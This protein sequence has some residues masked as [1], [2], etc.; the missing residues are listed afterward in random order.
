MRRLST[1]LLI[2]VILGAG[3]PGRSAPPVRREVAVRFGWPASY[4]PL[5]LDTE[6][7]PF[8]ASPLMQE[9]RGYLRANAVPYAFSACGKLVFSFDPDLVYPGNTFPCSVWL[10]PY[11]SM[12]L[13]EIRS[14]FGVEFGVDIRDRWT[15]INLTS[16]S[17]DFMIAIEGNGGLPLGDQ[18]IGGYD[19][20]EYTSIPI[21]QFLPESEILDLAQGVLE[22]FDANG[23]ST[24]IGEVD[25]FG[26]LVV[27][28][29]TLSMRVGET[30]VSLTNAGAASA[31]TAMIHVPRELEDSMASTFEMPVDPCY[32]FTIYKGMGLK[33]TAFGPLSFPIGYDRVFPA[34]GYTLPSL[35][36]LESEFQRAVNGATV[37]SEETFWI[38]FPINGRPPLP[39]LAIHDIVIN[40]QDPASQGKA[41]AGE[42]TTIAF[43][44]SNVG[45]TST[46]SNDELVVRF[47]V[48]GTQQQLAVLN[49]RGTAPFL[50]LGTNESIRLSF[51][52][53]F[54]EGSHNVELRSG[55]IMLKGYD[56]GEPVYGMGDPLFANH[57]KRIQVYAGPPRGTILGRVFSNPDS[58]GEGINGMLVRLNGLYRTL[59]TT[60]AY[61]GVVSSHGIYRFNGVPAGDYFLEYLPPAPT[62]TVGPRYWPRSVR[63]HH[64]GNG[65]TDLTQGSGLYM[66]QYQQLQGLVYTKDF[67][68]DGNPLSNVTVRLCNAALQET[69]SSPAG[70]FIFTNVPPSGRF[71]LTFD[72]PD[73]LLKQVLVNMNVEFTEQTNTTISGYYELPDLSWVNSG[74]ILLL[75]DTTPPEVSLEPFDN[76]GR[77]TT[78]MPFAFYGSDQDG[79]FTPAAYRWHVRNL[80][81]TLLLE[82]NWTPW[83]TNIAPGRRV[84]TTADM[85]SLGEGSYRFE[86]SARDRAGNSATTPYQTLALDKSAPQVTVTVA[87]GA[88]TIASRNAPV[89][90]TIT[91]SEPGTLKLEL[92]NDGIAWSTPWF[93]SSN[94]F[95][96]SDWELSGRDTATGTVTVRAR[97]TDA[98]GLQTIASD[99]ITLATVG[100]VQLAYGWEA[101]TN[102]TVPLEIAITPPEGTRTKHLSTY[103][104]SLSV[105]GSPQSVHLAQAFYLSNAIT[106]NRLIMFNL[107][108]I[109]EPGP[110]SVRAVTS[111]S[112]S[113]PS[114]AATAA[115]S[116]SATAEQIRTAR[117]MYDMAIP[118][119]SG[120]GTV[121]PPGTNYL[122]FTCD[123]TNQESRYTLGSGDRAFNGDGCPRFVFTSSTWTAAQD[124]ATFACE[125]W[126][127]PNGEIR[128]CT[129]GTPDTE[130]WTAYS[131]PDD[132]YRTVPAP[133]EGLFTTVV[134]YRNTVDSSR[135][136]DHLDTVVIDM[137]APAVNAVTLQTIDTKARGVLMA[138]DVSDARTRVAAMKWRFDSN[139][140][141]SDA[142]RSRPFLFCPPSFKNMT[143]VFI[144]AAYNETAPVTRTFGVDMSAP[145]LSAVTRNGLYYTSEPLVQW[146]FDASDDTRLDRI[147]LREARTDSNYPAMDPRTTDIDLPFPK[148][149]IGESDGHPIHDWVD[150]TYYFEAVAYDR[151]SNRSATVSVPVTLDRR[152]PV[153]TDAALTGMA[154]ES[155]VTGTNLLLKVSASDAIGPMQMRWRW[156][157]GVWSEW[158]SLSG[159]KAGLAIQGF[160][161]QPLQYE[162]DVEVRDAAGCSIA[163]RC[164]LEV[165][166]PPSTPYGIRPS[167]G[168]GSPPLLFGSDFSDPDSDS[169]HAS[170]FALRNEET[171][172]LETG[173]LDGLDRYTVPRSWVGM[174][175]KY[176]WR[177]RYL[178]SHGA[179]S[180]WSVWLTFGCL[181]DGDGDGIPDEVE[182]AC[183]TDFEDPDTDDDGIPDGM[184]DLNADGIVDPGETNPR[185]TDTDG[186]GLTDRTE[187]ADGNAR[188]G[189]AETSPSLPDTDNDRADDR[190]EVLSGTN[191]R[192]ASSSFRVTAFETLLPDGRRQLRWQGRGGSAYSV[193]TQYALTDASQP[194]TVTNMTANGGTAPWYVVPMT[195]TE[196]AYTPSN[197]FYYIRLQ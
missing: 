112:N 28:G 131:F 138:L 118:A 115:W 127:S 7:Q 133:G 100:A 190:H 69:R 3:L 142:F 4:S 128:I 80:A 78:P 97:V 159:G 125:F 56:H 25:L 2:G 121:L 9:F 169:W 13:T 42:S 139:A 1:W 64:A 54:N 109:G 180:E 90:V 43:T 86:V 166:R 132:P 172:L 63:F 146:L 76:N 23:F 130:P 158:M 65:V 184:E 22:V 129:D 75:E 179:W 77:R 59:V 95:T 155:P 126:N 49:N 72:H 61:D 150:G 89:S 182:T 160:L 66:R 73:H 196:P 51:T 154:G 50:V 37:T 152:P 135:D 137:T 119:Q 178:D 12:D 156:Q 120:N 143:W 148:C 168:T 177:C 171:I 62:N 167:G 96:V 32:N 58:R 110:F 144:D 83:P 165:N 27:R 174:T 183:G 24:G 45:G 103:A 107:N 189:P 5:D 14:D 149:K 193:M 163:T 79:R 123:S 31:Q 36:T 41:Y 29:H 84:E 60:S 170:Q 111:L 175:E 186:D 85:A 124:P 47:F 102:T 164:S 91:N 93:F 195:W 114:G 53:V 39:D 21:D 40:P 87:G 94:Q 147:C 15:G 117:V 181:P 197:R 162:I 151:A 173:S 26:E 104:G 113:D 141:Q 57:M 191:P 192:D 185:T 71:I 176:Q 30:D 8:P 46:L 101:W 20:L 161:P 10:E 194:A 11:D 140:W 82:G 108:V 38:S 68:P 134:S 153:L 81:G 48:D 55:H 99:S 33:L 157:D 88:A 34:G 105:G 106:F 6:W 116:W 145:T 74:A 52:A 122:V 67:P 188:L 70:S 187:D 98:A 17:K 35:S 44:L 92:S 18:L 136:G 16:F 19:T